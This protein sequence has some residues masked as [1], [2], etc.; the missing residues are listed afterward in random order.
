M[1]LRTCSSSN[2]QFLH[3]IAEHTGQYHSNRSNQ[4]HITHYN[5]SSCQ[6]FIWFAS[7]DDRID[8]LCCCWF[9]EMLKQC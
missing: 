4:N 6:N 2:G 9:K 5:N 8:P 1:F 7:S 3:T